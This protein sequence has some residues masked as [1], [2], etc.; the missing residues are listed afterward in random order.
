MG[1]SLLIMT[2]V[3]MYVGIKNIF[4]ITRNNFEIYPICI[5]RR[6]IETPVI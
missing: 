3:H 1:I 2:Y 4:N 6:Y 5:F